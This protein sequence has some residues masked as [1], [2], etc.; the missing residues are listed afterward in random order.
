MLRT[1][2]ALDRTLL[3]W[4]RTAFALEG[5]GLSLATYVSRWIAGGAIHGV[6]AETPRRL[7]LTLLAAGILAL[8]GGSLEHR[9]ATRRLRRASGVSAWSAVFAMSILMLVVS[10]LMFLGALL[11]TGPYAR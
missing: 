2:A 4:T 1:K 10:V 7:G 5:F 11:R 8:V 6:S 9:R 3:A